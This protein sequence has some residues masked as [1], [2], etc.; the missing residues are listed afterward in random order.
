MERFFKKYANKN[1]IDQLIHNNQAIIENF[2]DLRP[3]LFNGIT[4][5]HTNKFVHPTINGKR[6]T[7]LAHFFDPSPAF[8]IGALLR[9]I[10]NR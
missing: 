5:L 6:I 4:S 3:I 9:K 8:G 1:S 10:R 7:L 2:D